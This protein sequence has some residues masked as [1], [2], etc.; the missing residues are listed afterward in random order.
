MNA[1]MDGFNDYIRQNYRL[2]GAEGYVE[3]RPP[4][5]PLAYTSYK[6]TFYNFSFSPDSP[7]VAGSGLYA[8]SIGVHLNARGSAVMAQYIADMLLSIPDV[9]PAAPS[10]PST[11][12]TPSVGARSSI[13]TSGAK[14]LFV[15]NKLL[16]V[17]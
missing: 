12:S 6:G 13:L 17:S 8:D 5:G 4:G 10:I 2:L 11:P 1:A 15:K 9:A 16:R 14:P 3:T 7:Y